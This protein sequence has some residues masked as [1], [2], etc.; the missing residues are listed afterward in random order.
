MMYDAPFPAVHSPRMSTPALPTMG[1]YHNMHVT[2]E[3][4][5][6]SSLH[7]L[8]S[9]RGDFGRYPVVGADAQYQHR[10]S[11]VLGVSRAPGL[12]L[13]LYSPRISMDLAPRGMVLTS[14]SNVTWLWAKVRKGGGRGW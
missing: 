4:P 1:S 12:D 9:P 5:A 13:S 10:M 2:G 3:L 8:V 7:S 6:V 14:A 11:S